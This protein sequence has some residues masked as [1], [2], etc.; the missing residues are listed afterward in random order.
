ATA[1]AWRIGRGRSVTPEALREAGLRD[2][3]AERIVSLAADLNWNAA[4]LVDTI[5]ARR[6][7]RTRGFRKQTLEEMREN[8]LAEGYI[9]PRE[10]LTREQALARVLDR[11]ETGED[12][13]HLSRQ[14]VVDL[15]DYL[16]TSTGSNS[17][18]KEIS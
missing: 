17:A 2:T 16:W 1:E 15:F 8:L 12:D 11:V 9:D 13:D 3:F 10:P 6:D 5:E 7:E 4:D 18:G 14:E